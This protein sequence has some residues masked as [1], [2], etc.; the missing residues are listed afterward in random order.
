ML[1]FGV[2][3]LK[4]AFLVLSSPERNVYLTCPTGVTIERGEVPPAWPMGYPLVSLNQVSYAEC[5]RVY[6]PLTRPPSQL[7][8][9]LRCCYVLKSNLGH[10]WVFDRVENE[11]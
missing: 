1:S 7:F 9:V 4:R 5:M 11:M 10:Q 3:L 8:D 2:E 6:R